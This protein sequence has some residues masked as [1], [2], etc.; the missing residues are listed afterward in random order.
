[1]TQGLTLV[2]DD[3][4]AE[5]DAAFGSFGTVRKVRGRDIERDCLVDAD[6]L[7]VRSVTRVD[8][9][10][11]E[12]TSVRFVGTATAGI[13]HVDV[14]GL[15]RLG[16][17]FASAPGCN[18]LA[19]V[20]YVVT[21]LLLTLE[22]RGT[23]W[24]GTGPI[25]VVGFGQVGRRL[26]RALRDLGFEVWVSDPP[27][28]E[29]IAAGAVLDSDP[30]S[31]M[32]GEETY[33]ALPELLQACRV[34]SL[35]VPFEHRGPHPTAS[36]VGRAQLAA[37]PEDA[38]LVHTCRGTVV[39]ETALLAWIRQGAGRAVLDVW[40]GEPDIDPAMV[41]AATWATPHI[42]G[43][44]L[45][46]KL[47]ATSLVHRA[48]CAWLGETPRSEV[49]DALRDRP[50]PRIEVDESKPGCTILTHAMTQTFDLPRDDEALRRIVAGP[51]EQRGAAFEAS[52]RG[53]AWRREPSS[54]RL[55]LTRPHVF[56]PTGVPLE[57]AAAAL[58]F[59]VE[60]RPGAAS[61][62]G[63]A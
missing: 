60:Q 18:A 15:E 54:H 21:A 58:G 48:L 6:A 3:A 2:A 28:A 27:L 23:G 57:R 29:R 4:I 8:P 61:R 55:L 24:L 7:L 31:E 38:L 39:D 20:Q 36:L 37:M 53:Y 10:L 45:E 14:G 59:R 19:V 5:L 1:M 49:E 9:E 46:G 30:L 63:S 11:L 33:C 44:T 47:R 51:P 42:A 35:H 13:D 34:V 16:I 41:E 52:R 32:A 25:G 17:T 22:Q 50:V 56:E 43:Y 62:P 26:T 40:A 12:G